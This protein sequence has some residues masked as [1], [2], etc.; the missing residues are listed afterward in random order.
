V[1]RPARRT[2]ILM[3]EA[4]GVSPTEDRVQTPRVDTV[5]TARVTASAKGAVSA[6]RRDAIVIRKPPAVL[7]G[8]ARESELALRRAVA[9][10]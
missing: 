9:L 5:V 1:E 4:V 3:V 6:A 7:L 10:L 2:A 8:Y